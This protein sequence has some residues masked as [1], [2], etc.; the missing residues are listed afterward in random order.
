[1]QYNTQTNPEPHSAHPVY[2][3]TET[4]GLA[5][6]WEIVNS[7]YI[8]LTCLIFHFNKVFYF[9]LSALWAVKVQDLQEYCKTWIHWHSFS[10]LQHFRPER[11]GERTRGTLPKLFGREDWSV[12]PKCLTSIKVFVTA[13][14]KMPTQ[15]LL[16]STMPG[17]FAPYSYQGRQRYV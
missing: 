6:I 8:K 3:S 1:M 7:T 2:P 12:L 14:I 10:E 9:Q 15:C 17:L 16:H 13:D 11:I 4:S 5:W